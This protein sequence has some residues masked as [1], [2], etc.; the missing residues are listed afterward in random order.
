MATVPRDA[1]SC[2]TT[3]FGL[4]T[5]PE[6]KLAHMNWLPS[7][8]RETVLKLQTRLLLKDCYILCNMAKVPTKKA[9]LQLHWVSYSC[10]PAVMDGGSRMLCDIC[11]RAVRPL[12]LR[13]DWA[14]CAFTHSFSPVSK[15]YHETSNFAMYIRHKAEAKPT[16][17]GS[18]K[19]A[20][21]YMCA[22]LD[23][24]LSETP[25]L[26]FLAQA[27]LDARLKTKHR[28]LCR[29]MVACRRLGTIN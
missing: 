10:I 26:Y 5:L 7:L 17:N 20:P 1:A 27:P 15:L 16:G 28:I 13:G 19:M 21:K 22:G 4:L 14:R 12:P 18:R 8:R 6:S 11:D 2:L 25:T 23:L 29:L 9:N 3:A 24:V